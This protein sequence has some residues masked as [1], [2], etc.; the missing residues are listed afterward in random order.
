MEKWAAWADV[1]SKVWHEPT[2]A[3]SRW[4][5]E[6]AAQTLRWLDNSYGKSNAR[7]YHQTS[8]S[9]ADRQGNLAVPFP[10]RILD[11]R[12]IPSKWTR[13]LH[14][15]L[16]LVTKS[17]TK[18]G[19]YVTLS[20]R[21]GIDHRL[22]L[23][24]ASLRAHSRWIR[25]ETLPRT[26]Q[27]AVTVARCLGFRYIW[28]DALCIIQDDKQ[29][30][31]Q[32]AAKMASVYQNSSCTIAT[33]AAHDDNEG[34][35]HASRSAVR[36][37]RPQSISLFIT[38]SNLS[39]RGW[40][41]QERI[42]SRRLLHFTASG[43][44]LEDASGFITPD[45]RT[46]GLYDP[47]KD[48][49]FNLED[50]HHDPCG[51]YRLVERFTACRLTLETDR[52]PAV[53]GLAKC[54][55]DQIDDGHYLWGLWSRSIHQGLLWTIVNQHP[56][57]LLGHGGDLFTE[58]APSWSWGFWTGQARFPDNLSSCKADC[59][60]VE[61]DRTINETARPGQVMTPRIQLNFLRTI[62]LQ[63]VRI[64]RK[65]HVPP[66]F[67]GIQFCY[68]IPEQGLDCISL[69]DERNTDV[70]VF[71]Q[72]T[73]AVVAHHHN[74]ETFQWDDDSMDR[75]TWVYYF[76]L[77]APGASKDGIFCY[78]RIGIGS[79]VS[80]V[81]RLSHTLENTSRH[82][83]DSIPLDNIAGLGRHDDYEPIL[84]I[85]FRKLFNRAE[86]RTILLS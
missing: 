38:G 5:R 20:H 15:G 53:W 11:I 39:R 42:L 6:E 83:L 7:M 63:N 8:S 73:L 33:H 78:R 21:W 72:L 79:S 30:W 49:K 80:Y 25:F 24:K 50:S 62:D 9:N 60:V 84:S 46:P 43:L 1:L 27:D 67:M 10:T 36:G 64:I 75:H 66:R 61:L 45:G 13:G 31:L 48:N 56:E 51:W 69:D 65:S 22:I 68:S 37:N 82:S 17:T 12:P 19:N 70:V 85:W 77:L 34:F 54:L 57:K 81:D 29:D 74:V 52:L 18:R 16:R 55:G 58:A 76:L 86:E 59:K 14:G 2:D 40:V 44:F 28:I 35:L 41:F 23:D 47:W 3:R 26:Y 4:D 32:E 71:A